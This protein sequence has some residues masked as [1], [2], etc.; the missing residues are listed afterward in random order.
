MRADS[1]SMAGLVALLVDCEGTVAGNQ[2][3]VRIVQLP[4]G[5]QFGVCLTSDRN[6]QGR[7]KS[8]MGNPSDGA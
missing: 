2:K 8:P 6:I 1:G 5:D 7:K 3:G 4:D